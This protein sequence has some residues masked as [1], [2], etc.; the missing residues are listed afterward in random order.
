MKSTPKTS[1]AY[2]ILAFFGGM[3]LTFN[4]VW[5]LNRYSV[6]DHE[7]IQLHTDDTALSSSQYCPTCGPDCQD[8]IA[9]KQK[10]IDELN[11]K[12]REQ[13]VVQ[14]PKLPEEVQNLLADHDLLGNDAR[15]K[16][17]VVK[18]GDDK[19]VITPWSE[20]DDQYKGTCHYFKK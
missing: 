11:V 6:L 20:Y 3:F 13:I 2:L 10:I 7:P 12:L 4:L 8:S 16:S 5:M 19:D 14:P 1:R 17:N 18:T 15:V 9:A